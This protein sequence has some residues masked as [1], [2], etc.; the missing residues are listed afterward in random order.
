MPFN[1][2]LLPGAGPTPG[3]TIL[4]GDCEVAPSS[5]ALGPLQVLQ[6]SAKTVHLVDLVERGLSHNCRKIPTKKYA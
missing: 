5:S 4:A 2:R 3:Q 6:P 1:P